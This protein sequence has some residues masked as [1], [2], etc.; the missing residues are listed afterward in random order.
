MHLYH[1]TAYLYTVSIACG[2][3]RQGIGAKGAVDV[4]MYIKKCLE[5]LIWITI[6]RGDSRLEK[7]LYIILQSVEMV[8]PLHFLSILKIFLCLTLR[9]LAR[10]CGDLW[11][12]GFGVVDI[13]KAVDFMDKAFDEITKDRI[14]C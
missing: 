1:P 2:G 7:K 5:F 12:Y 8:S 3:L 6:W 13:K 10:N 4:L 11:D 9:W 14:L